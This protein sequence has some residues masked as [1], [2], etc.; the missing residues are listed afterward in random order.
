MRIFMILYS[1]PKIT[2]QA[3]KSKRIEFSVPK[4][5]RRPKRRWKNDIEIIGI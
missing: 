1:A 3:I 2:A 5:E 4:L